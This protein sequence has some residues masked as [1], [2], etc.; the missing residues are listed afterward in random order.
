MSGCAQPKPPQWY[1]QDNNDPQTVC[2]FGSGETASDAKQQAQGD[3]ASRVGVRIGAQFQSNVTVY[4]DDVTRNRT[5]DVKSENLLKEMIDVAVSRYSEEKSWWKHLHFME[6]CISKMDIKTVLE[7]SI[8]KQM[9]Q[10]QNKDLYGECLLRSTRQNYLQLI[11]ETSSNVK[12]LSQYDPQ[13]EYTQTFD[14]LAQMQAKAKFIQPLVIKSNDAQLTQLLTPLAAKYG[15]VITD[16][17]QGNGILTIELT[18]EVLRDSTIGKNQKNYLYVARVL[19]RLEKG[20]KTRLYE[21]S[22]KSVDQAKSPQSAKLNALN[23]LAKGVERSTFSTA[24]SQY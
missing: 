19:F 10:L 9:A 4:G 18:G 17:G 16:G 8:E 7:R 22:F 14:Q 23:K 11:A 20:C 24:L 6:A 15:I 3:L 5:S 2:G 13:G 21:G 1:Y 12:L